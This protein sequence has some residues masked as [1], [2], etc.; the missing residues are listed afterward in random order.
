MVNSN[1][2]QK[3]ENRKQRTKTLNN[4]KNGRKHKDNRTKG[5]G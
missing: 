2:K 1:S 4:K 3:T 5:A